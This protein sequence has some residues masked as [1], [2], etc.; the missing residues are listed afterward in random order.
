MLCNVEK[1]PGRHA[2]VMKI[3]VFIDCEEYSAAFLNAIRQILSN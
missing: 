1:G 2:S 3:E